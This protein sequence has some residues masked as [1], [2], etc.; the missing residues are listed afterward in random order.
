MIYDERKKLFTRISFRVS[1][2]FFESNSLIKLIDTECERYFLHKTRLHLKWM[3][4][5]LKSRK[6][7]VKRTCKMW[8]LPHQNTYACMHKIMKY[9]KLMNFFGWENHWS[10]GLWFQLSC[11]TWDSD[12]YSGTW[13]FRESETK[14]KPKL[15]EG[16]LLSQEVQLVSKNQRLYF[17]GYRAIE[18]ELNSRLKKYLAGIL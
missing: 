4:W 12:S 5:V 11:A 13:S 3:E 16:N 7:I 8:L 15:R 9:L 1:T 18:Q 2:N 6:Q 14:D 10:T 17:T